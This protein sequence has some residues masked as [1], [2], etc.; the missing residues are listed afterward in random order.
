MLYLNRKRKEKLKAEVRKM[1]YDLNLMILFFLSGTESGRKELSDKKN[2]E[3]LKEYCQIIKSNPLIMIDQYMDMLLGDGFFRSL[4]M[5]GGNKTE[6][7][8]YTTM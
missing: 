5:E 2:Q 3:V 6:K 4:E 8:G 1:L 7:Y